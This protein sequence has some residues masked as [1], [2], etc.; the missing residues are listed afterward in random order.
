MMVTSFVFCLSITTFTGNHRL[1]DLL[2]SLACILKK[3]KKGLRRASVGVFTPMIRKALLL[4]TE[5]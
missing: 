4:Y 5:E 2:N 3:N 1:E